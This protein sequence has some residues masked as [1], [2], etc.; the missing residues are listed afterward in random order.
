MGSLSLLQGIF[1]AQGSNLGL[2]HFRWILYQL[3]RLGSPRILEW[4][5]SGSSRPRNRTGVSYIS[6]GFFTSWVLHIDEKYGSLILPT[7]GYWKIQCGKVCELL[8]SSFRVSLW[9]FRPEDTSHDQHPTHPWEA[10][11]YHIFICHL[12]MSTNVLRPI[13][14]GSPGWTL[15]SQMPLYPQGL[16]H[17]GLA[18]FSWIVLNCG[19][20]TLHQQGSTSLELWPH[21]Y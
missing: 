1:P 14:L 12:Q 17:N 5:S 18:L 10:H 15:S 8:S 21:V 20:T 11:P 16:P 7:W 13:C 4:V 2:P 3:S 19:R 9:A 6:G